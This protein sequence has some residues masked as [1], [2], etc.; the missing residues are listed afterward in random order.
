MAEDVGTAECE[1]T[2]PRRT[3]L[4][5]VARRPVGSE[6]VRLVLDGPPDWHSLPGQFI[7]ILC[8]S[9]PR[10][11]RASDGRMLDDADGAEWP[12]ATGLELGRKW[13][14]VRR[15]LSIS[16][17]V[18]DGGRV[19]L[20]LL[21]R[22][23]GTG[24]RFLATRPPGASL[25]VVGPLGNHFTP[26]DGDR[27]CVLVGGGCGL[28]PIFGLADYLAGLGHRC[29]CFLGAADVTDMPVTFLRPPVAT[30]QRAEVVST[31]AEFAEDE[32]PAVL[33]TDDGSAGY[34]GFVTDALEVYL[35]EAGP[36]EPP[37]LYGCGPSGMLK[38]LSD[39]AARREMPCQVSLEGFM[40]CGI[41]VCL[42]CARKRRDPTS[43]KGWTFRL[44]CRQG[45]VVD[46][47]EIVWE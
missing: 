16:R 36:A 14:F 22:I 6:F 39:L 2:R 43:E 3:D 33:A 40:G 42:S 28:A 45:P 20:D 13:P 44:T 10:A 38:A 15:P 37:A 11:V 25:D 27:L 47:R 32:I 12:Q 30:Q 9:D 8:E 35:N 19:R 21:I 1:V 17:V 5:L 18:R 29:I 34:H 24:S 26:P 7:N 31:I 41:G 46:A 23:V 4:V